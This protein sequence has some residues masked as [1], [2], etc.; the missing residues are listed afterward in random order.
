MKRNEYQDS[1]IVGILF[2]FALDIIVQLVIKWRNL[3][4]ASRKEE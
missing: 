2:A 1:V 3:V 4:R